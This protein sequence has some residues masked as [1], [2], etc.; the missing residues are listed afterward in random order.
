MSITPSVKNSIYNYNKSLEKV[1]VG[2]NGTIV[3]SFSLIYKN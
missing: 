1:S 2:F 3:L